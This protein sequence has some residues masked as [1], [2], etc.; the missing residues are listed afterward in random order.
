MEAKKIGWKK[1]YLKW[2]QKE[3]AEYFA[4]VNEASKK[5]KQW[6]IRTALSKNIAISDGKLPLKKMQ[7]FDLLV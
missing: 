4:R 3:I 7:V 6:K 2:L 5:Y 1:I